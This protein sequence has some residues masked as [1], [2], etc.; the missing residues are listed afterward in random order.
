MPKKSKNPKKAAKAKPERNPFLRKVD[1]HV[2]KIPPRSISFAKQPNCQH[3]KPETA[4]LSNDKLD[5]LRKEIKEYLEKRMLLHDDVVY[6]I[7]F[8]GLKS[9]APNGYDE[10]MKNVVIATAIDHILARDCSVESTMAEDL[11]CVAS[12]LEEVDEKTWVMEEGVTYKKNIFPKVCDMVN[13]GC[14]CCCHLHEPFCW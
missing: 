5:N 2:A 1:K 12:A 14:E 13:N 9:R 11:V 8:W 4:A 3:L 6:D 7:M 10:H